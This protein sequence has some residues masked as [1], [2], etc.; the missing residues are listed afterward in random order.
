MVEEA[1]SQPL[2]EIGVNK[3]N[4]EL[5]RLKHFGRNLPDVK[6]SVSAVHEAAYLESPISVQSKQIW[7]NNL[8]GISIGK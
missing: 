5:F 3:F 6:Q 8:I 4:Q 2:N 7:C 1:N